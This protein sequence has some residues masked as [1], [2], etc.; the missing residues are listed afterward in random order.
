[1]VKHLYRVIFLNQSSVYEIYA[2]SISEG[3]LFGFLEVRDL[4]FGNTTALIVD[5][6]EERL[7]KEFDGVSAFYIPV[8]QVIRIDE[9]SQ[10]GPA[11]IRDIKD[12][13]NITPLFPT[14]PPL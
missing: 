5:P 4:V 8:H 2:D 9:V 7:K 6:S 3:G 11:K 14:P 1:M 10:R 12:K 13:S